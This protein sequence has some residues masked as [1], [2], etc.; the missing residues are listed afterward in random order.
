MKKEPPHICVR[1]FVIVY[2][3]TLQ[4]AFYDLT[5]S[6][7]VFSPPYA[8]IFAVHHGHAQGREDIVE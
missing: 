7:Y 5:D 4:Q 8:H 6:L 3:Y 1:N 2:C